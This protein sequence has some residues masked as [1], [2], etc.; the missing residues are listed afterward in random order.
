M[1]KYTWKLPL[2]GKRQRVGEGEMTI[3]AAKF[4][5]R[6]FGSVISINNSKKNIIPRTRE[7]KEWQKNNFSS[8][9]VNASKSITLI[10]Q[11]PAT[12]E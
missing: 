2:E 5:L 11:G 9:P 6:E 7:G 1:C 12:P 8:C 3:W 10:L 4:N